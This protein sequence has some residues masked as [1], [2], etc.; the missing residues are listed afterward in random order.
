MYTFED[1]FDIFFKKSFY[2]S[3]SEEFVIN[4]IIYKQLCKKSAYYKSQI[5]EFINNIVYKQLCKKII[6]IHHYEFLRLFLEVIDYKSLFGYV[7]CNVNKH[8]SLNTFI[9]PNISD[10]CLD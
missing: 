5:E 1:L 10:T 6:N 4:D 3:E 8:T 7:F 9:W 2:K